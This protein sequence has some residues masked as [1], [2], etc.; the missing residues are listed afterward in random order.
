M[1]NFLQQALAYHQSGRLDEA[2]QLCAAILK[3]EPQQLDALYLRGIVAHD[4]RQYELAVDC[5]RAAI[6]LAPDNAA[7]RNQLGISHQALGQ[8]QEA[9]ACYREA[10]RLQPNLAEAYCNLGALFLSM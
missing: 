10:L 1:H 4:R 8:T 9:I 3:V 2:D 5:F 7:Y 6:A